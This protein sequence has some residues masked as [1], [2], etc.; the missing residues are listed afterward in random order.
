[1]RKAL[2]LVFVVALLACTPAVLARFPHEHVYLTLKAFRE[3]DTPIT[4]L[5]GDKLEL[6]QAGNN[7][8][9]AP[10]IHYMDDKVTSYIGTH[11][12]GTYEQ[13]LIEAGSDV[14]ARCVCYGM[15]LHIAQDDVHVYDYGVPK[16]IKKYWG[17]NV[18][19]HAAAERKHEQMLLS[20]IQEG[21]LG[22]VVGYNEVVER[23]KHS[24]DPFFSQEK[25]INLFNR[26]TGTDMY[27]DIAIVGA[28][29][30]GERWDQEVYGK[31][32]GLP[33][34]TYVLI[35]GLI[36]VGALFIVLA[37]LS[38]TSV[39][40]KAFS[41]VK[42]SLFALAG[43]ILLASILTGQ[44]W[45]WFNYLLQP[46]GAVMSVS[47]DE[48]RVWMEKGYEH[49]KYF[50]ENEELPHADASGLSYYD[51]DGK[52]HRGALNEAETRGIVLLVIVGI[53]YL[54]LLVWM[55]KKFI[56]G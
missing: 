33:A 23:T 18:V 16:W 44:S 21:K 7:G 46:V 10:V 36:A 49:T 5:C 25:F 20:D 34:W 47:D 37:L 51:E 1:M 2:V 6:V 42:G 19:L 50:L 31:K 24:Y 54:G 41:V 53:L 3:L 11:T 26:A 22:T 52:Y 27:S 13:C 48:H 9:D 17:S 45:V 40:F 4:R 30:R 29:L 43:L 32:V 8:A 35:G 39:G 56:K 15:G 55:A 28:S 14:D 12:K 38:K